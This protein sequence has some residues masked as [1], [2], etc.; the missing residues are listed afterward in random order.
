LRRTDLVYPITAF[1]HTLYNFLALLIAAFKKEGGPGIYSEA[2]SREW[3]ERMRILR[4]FGELELEELKEIGS[5]YGAGYAV[6][7]IK[8]AR[9][10]YLPLLFESGQSGVIKL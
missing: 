2:F 10:L 7:K 8:H 3:R 4:N 6:V 5:R 1:V 9:K